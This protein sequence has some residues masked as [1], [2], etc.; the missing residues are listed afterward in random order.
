MAVLEKVKAAILP[1]GT[2]IPKEVN[3]KLYRGRERML[4]GS[5]KR[6]EYLEFWRNNHYA[7][8]D[9]KNVLQFQATTTSVRGTGKQPWRQ[10]RTVNLIFDAV[11]HQVSSAT[12]RVP[13]YGVAPST[14]DQEDA[15]AADLAEKIAL[16]GHDKWQIRQL[17]V[18]ATR[19]AVVAEEAFA[20]PYWDSS[21]G[22]FI[23]GENVGLGEV[24]IKLFSGNQTYWEPGVPFDESR[25]YCVEYAK[26][27]DEV[28]EMEGYLGGTLVPDSDALSVAR[29]GTDS[30]K[31]TRTVLVKEYLERPCPK[32]PDGRWLTIANDRQILE[33]RGYPYIDGQGNAVDEPVLH[34]LVYCD[35]P[36]SD[37]GVGLVR[38]LVDAQRMYNWARSK[39]ME[40]AQLGLVPQSFAPPGFMRKQRISDEPGRHYEVNGDPNTMLRWRDNISMPGE[41]FQMLELAEQEIGRLSAQNAIPSQVEAGKAIQ[42]LIER[43]QTRGA[44]FLNNLADW[45]SSVM[46]HC[47]MLVQGHYTE[48]RVV[49][50][51]GS[52]GWE[53]V[54][55]FLGADL[56]GQADVRVTPASIEPRTR[57]QVEQKV[58]LAMQSGWIPPEQGLHALQTGQADDLVKGVD[59]AIGRIHRVIQLI[60]KGPE[61]LFSAPTRITSE[62]EPATIPGPVDPATGMPTAAPNPNAGL[63]VTDPQTGL[64][65]QD[66][67]WMPQE[68]DNLG[69]WKSEMQ[70]W[71]QTEEAEHLEPP[72]QDAANQVYQAILMVEARQQQR[73]AMQQE[74][75][76]QSLGMNNAAKPQGPPPL[77]DQNTPPGGNPAPTSNQPPNQ[78]V[79][80]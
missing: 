27:P 42:A 30:A 5:A 14:V 53:T 4:Q 15:S 24:K 52:F 33:E 58:Y 22:P 63:P 34:R 77:P 60:K 39:M 6:N 71:F 41:L 75:T 54:A 25:W 72:I 12:Q 23:Q 80:S 7:Y 8:V 61:A 38:H 2:D 64:P 29:K 79:P 66:P 74:M 46:R 37:R 70:S 31:Q 55:D 49:K 68:W 56:R 44:Q 50:I 59:L 51:K 32:Y 18:G 9:E 62:T 36:D 48:D 45:Y 1:P 47:L 67:I 35:D 43:D 16:Y 17:A 28:M 26:T 73:A 19:L 78:A 65:R 69:I 21:V 10:R 57:E 76:A 20:W 13:S 40:Y 11:E 3:D